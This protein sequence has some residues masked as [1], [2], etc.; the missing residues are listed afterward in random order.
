M[1][2]LKDLV[3]KGVRLIVADDEAALASEADPSSPPR[4][5][6][7]P[8]AAFEEPLQPPPAVVESSVP[9]DVDDFSAVYA[10]AG[11]EVPAHGYGVDKAE[12]MLSNKRLAALSREVKATAVMAALEAAGAPMRDIIQDGVRRDTALDTFEAAK[13]S[14]LQVL[15]RQSQE[16]VQAIKDEIDEFLRSKNAELEDL[17][18]ATEAAEKAFA[19][20][21]ARKR[22][23][24]DRIHEVVA[25]FIEGADNPITAGPRAAATTPSP[26]KPAPADS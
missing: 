13:Q 18:K 15:Q 6:D 19:A 1:S 17:K 9:A 20:M 11:I 25:H 12:E 3:S 4:D 16:R 10:E 23:E 7:I 22:K 24:E 21:Q 8:A 2:R 14:E 26:A 5:R